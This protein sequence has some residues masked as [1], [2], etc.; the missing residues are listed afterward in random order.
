MPQRDARIIEGTIDQIRVAVPLH[1]KDVFLRIGTETVWAIDLDER[2]LGAL[3]ACHFDGIP[4]RVGV[5][6]AEH[7]LN[8]YR[9][10]VPARG[11]P[12]PPVSYQAAQR[13][14][15]RDA[16]VCA[17]VGA[18][19]LGAAWLFGLDSM[20]RMF[21]MVFSLVIALIAL[22]LAGSALFVLWHNRRDR[23][24]ILASEALFDPAQRPP[25]TK[26]APPPPPA[27][28][29]PAALRDDGEPPILLVRGHLD[30]I[31]HETR[32]VH[33]GPTYGHYRFSVDGRHFL[34][35]VDESHGSWQP[36][37]AQDDRVEM[38]AH[39]SPEPDAPHAV[40]ALRN[41]E[42][43]R[44]Y[45]CHLRFRAGLGKDTPVGVGMNQRAPMLKMI[46]ALMLAAWLFLV[47]I[48]W[49]SDADASHGGFANMALF[50]LGMFFL[51]WLGFALPLLWLD[52]R[53]RMGKPTRRQ[54]ITERIYA[55]LD[56]GTPFAP[57]RRIEEV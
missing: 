11:A 41:L 56:L 12:L 42:D 33:K 17:A 52:T 43:G 46:G 34:M 45:M 16:M 8:R 54:R 9:W 1:R 40:Y 36:F 28:L 21:L 15:G 2:H 3:R 39:A 27:R 29:A 24:A 31:T 48:S 32:H 20:T 37:L 18:A 22:I 47:G 44:A 7:G 19:A 38:A 51:V 14:S 57:T 4:V 23:P 50:V 26:S 13:R 53:W 10:A 25:A 30:G 5:L 49:F 6:E 35:T 55:L